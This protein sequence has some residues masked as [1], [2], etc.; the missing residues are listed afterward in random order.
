MI[1]QIRQPRLCNPVFV[2]RSR[3]ATFPPRTSVRFFA[4]A[5]EHEFRV[6]TRVNL[7]AN[8]REHFSGFRHATPAIYFL[9]LAAYTTTTAEAPSVLTTILCLQRMANG[10][11]R[12]SCLGLKCTS[13]GSR[14]Y[15]AQHVYTILILCFLLLDGSC[16]AASLKSSMCRKL[17]KSPVSWL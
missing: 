15:A 5:N 9:W 10:D 14:R 13:S 17:R 16:S 7:I 12:G 2:A 6:F 1:V 3:C 8:L 4:M 11:N